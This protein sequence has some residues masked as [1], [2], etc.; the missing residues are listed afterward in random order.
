VNI[1]NFGLAWDG[2]PTD[3]DVLGIVHTD[4]AEIFSIAPNPIKHKAIISSREPMQ[5]ASLSM[6][7][8][9]GRQVMFLRG[10]SGNTQQLDCGGLAP[11]VYLVRI[12]A[13]GKTTTK[14]IV[15]SD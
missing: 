14:K 10:I 15:V 5:D 2:I 11:G 13:L 6:F 12:D 7:D 8:A 9:L 1:Y 3:C 4:D